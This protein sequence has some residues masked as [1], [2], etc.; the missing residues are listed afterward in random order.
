MLQPPVNDHCCKLHIFFM[1]ACTN[2]TCMNPHHVRVNRV[3]LIMQF[4]HKPV[5]LKWNFISS[6]VCLLWSL[7][8]FPFSKQCWFC[9][10]K[11]MASSFI[12]HQK[13]GLLRNWDPLTYN[14]IFHQV[15]H[16][17]FVFYGVWLSPL[18]RGQKQE[19]TTYQYCLSS[20]CGKNMGWLL[21]LYCERWQLIR[22][23]PNKFCQYFCKIC[24]RSFFE[25]CCHPINKSIDLDVAKTLGTNR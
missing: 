16:I 20:L 14:Q 17:P 4:E 5:Q 22:H 25:F 24:A 11:R 1:E 2:L 23:V 18:Y 13:S 8:V 19:I 21:C 6:P 9:H 15:N 12:F 3:C 10:L 7:Q